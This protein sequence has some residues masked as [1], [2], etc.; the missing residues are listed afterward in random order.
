MKF[1]SALSI[2]VAVSILFSC[3]QG[4]EEDFGPGKAWIPTSVELAE[5]DNIEEIDLSDSAYVG[6]SKKIANYKNLKF[7]I[8]RN[9]QLTKIQFNFFNLNLFKKLSFINKR[10]IIEELLIKLK[11]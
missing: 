2:L 10:E 11:K 7:L 5:A 8:L 6:I 1:I 3:S 9:N 4:N